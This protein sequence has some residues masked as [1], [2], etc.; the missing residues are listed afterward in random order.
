[1]CLRSV[2]MY[3]YLSGIYVYTKEKESFVSMSMYEKDM[4]VVLFFTNKY[5]SIFAY[6][7]GI[8]VRIRENVF[9]ISN[10]PRINVN[11]WARHTYRSL[12]T[13]EY[14]SLFP[15]ISGIYLYTRENMF[16][17]SNLSR[18]DANTWQTHIYR[19]LFSQIN[20]GLFSHICQVYMY[21]PE[22]RCSVS[23]ISLVSMSI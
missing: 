15:Y 13:Y 19:G 10:L 5:R 18:I 9:C 14:T 8:H 7:P 11:T 20:I 4:C 17:I 21:T 1:M 23:P 12:S 2:C 16:Y 3:T 6:V 22:R